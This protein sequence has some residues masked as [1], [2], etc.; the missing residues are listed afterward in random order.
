M[1]KLVLISFS[2]LLV[3]CAADEDSLTSGSISDEFTKQV[4]VFGIPVVG[5]SGVSDTKLL[6]VAK[7]LAQ[8]LD[9]NE[10]GSADD[11]LVSLYMSENN[12]IMAVT[13]TQAELDSID[14]G[15]FPS[16]GNNV[17]TVIADEIKVTTDYANDG[18]D[19]TIEEV[20]HMVTS[21]GFANS[22]SEVFGENT[23]S[24]IANAMDTARGGQFT[25][26][27]SS[28]PSGA[29][30]TYSDSSCDYKCQVTEYTYWVITTYLGIQDFTGRPS[31]IN[32]EW[33]FTT[34]AEITDNSNGD[35]AAVA[36][37]EATGVDYTLPT[38]APDLT[39]NGSTL[40]V[41]AR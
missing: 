24:E 13:A 12:S 26:I 22:Y 14:F 41:E 3:S 30:F 18:F 38:V 39:Y 6:H 25:S 33:G 28:Y 20:L 11:S 37:I 21:T 17:V 10:D 7:V 19:P 8:Y 31:Q 34:N 32:S 5:T 9:S 29:W 4:K 23:G 27:P 1:I 40:T 15:S 36:I 2:I 35:T 16:K